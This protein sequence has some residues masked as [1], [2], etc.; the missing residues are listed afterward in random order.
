MLDRFAPW[1]Q[2]IHF[3]VEKPGRKSL[4][5]APWADHFPSVEIAIPNFDADF[6][7]YLNKMMYECMIQKEVGLL[8]YFP[9]RTQS[10]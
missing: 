7:E 4:Y 8:A 2:A 9:A 1:V 10:A 6:D 5:K 3:R